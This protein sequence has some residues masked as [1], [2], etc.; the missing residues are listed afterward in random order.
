M[1]AL[2]RYSLERSTRVR[3]RPIIQHRWDLTP[4]RLAEIFNAPMMLYLGLL[5]SGHA[6]GREC[7]EGRP[8]IPSM[9]HLRGAASV[10]R[11]HL[12]QA[13]AGREVTYAEVMQGRLRDPVFR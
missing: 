1:G 11:R 4:A 2:S 6:G 10:P 9:L 13:G 3:R 8:V 7:R 12:A 5:R